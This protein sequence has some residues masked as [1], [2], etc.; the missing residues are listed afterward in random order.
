MTAS[1]TTTFPR[2][3]QNRKGMPGEICFPLL[4]STKPCL[5]EKLSR[6]SCSTQVTEWSR[7]GL[8]GGRAAGLQK[9][10]ELLDLRGGYGRWGSRKERER[11]GEGEVVTE[12]A[13]EGASE[14][15]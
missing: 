9:L 2:F 10:S 3:S 4:C 5:L 6:G 15:D 8:Q 1:S 12:K 7:P 11:G 13:R 14:R